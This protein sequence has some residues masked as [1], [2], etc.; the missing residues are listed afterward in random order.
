MPTQ[1]EMGKQSLAQWLAYLE[2]L[3]PVNI[4]MGLARIEQ[5]AQRLNFDFS[6]TQVITVAGTNG[7]GS[8][9][10]VL[11]KML[12]AQGYSVGVYSSPHLIDYRERV[13]INDVLPQAN[14]FCEAFTQIEAARGDTSLTYFEFGT[15]AAIMLMLAHQCQFM[16]LEVGLGGRLDATNI[17]TPDMAVITTIDLDHQDWLGDT[18]EKIALE[19]AGIVRPSASVIIGDLSPPQSLIDKMAELNAKVTW[20]DQQFSHSEQADAWTFTFA[21]REAFSQLI[22]PSLPL[23]NVATA[24]ATLIELDK[25]PAPNQLNDILKQCHLGGRFQHVADEPLTYVDVAHNPQS[26]AYLATRIERCVKQHNITK[27]RAVV[28]MLKDKEIALALA[29]LKAQIDE[30]Y[31]APSTGPRGCSAEYVVEQLNQIGSEHRGS[32]TSPTALA[33]TAIKQHSSI[34]D[35]YFAATDNTSSKELVIVFGSFITVGEVLQLLDK[36]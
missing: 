4:D 13:R 24:L 20:R 12:L 25:L 2:Q 15:L 18:R 14:E 36:S 35:A 32:D 17:V 21:D 30:W 31:I 6:N 26:T 19:K 3:H 9:C 28:A 5:V 27:V 10:R 34:Q 8:T 11:E 23:Q 33:P 29:P 16:I 7:K 1:H 22:K